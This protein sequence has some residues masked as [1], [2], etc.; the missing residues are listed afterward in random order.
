MNEHE[1]VR[2]YEAATRPS[3][4]FA[5]MTMERSSPESVTWPILFAI[6]C[7]A[8]VS[9]LGVLFV[10]EV[11]GQAPCN[12]CW[13]QR[14]FM[15]PL[16][17]VLG[18]ACWRG[19]ARAWIYALPLAAIGGL[20]AAFHL[21]LYWKIISRAI[22]PCGPGPSCTSSDMTVFGAIPLPL[23]SL[24]A[25]VMIAAGLIALRRRRTLP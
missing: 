13:G 11:L 18:I 7:V 10:G 16:T 4:P 2:V 14:A 12:L 22:E 21:L 1:C 8:L 20:I 24:L 17:V 9:T 3:G 6:W 5:T 23:L 25:F 19:D 15:F